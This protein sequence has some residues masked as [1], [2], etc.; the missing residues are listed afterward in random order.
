MTEQQQNAEDKLA[1]LLVQW[2][3]AWDLN[4]DIP[5][6]DLCADCPEL[7][8]PLERQIAMLK[9]MAWMKQD[10]AGEVPRS[11]AEETDPLL[12]KTLAG[13]YRIDRLI[14]EGGFGRV[15]RGF[16][17]ELQRQVAIKVARP[18]RV[19]SAEQADDLLE[20]ARRA[21]R[22]RHPGIVSV[23]DAGRDNGQVFIVSDLIEGESLADLI[24]TSR[25]GPAEAARLLA[26]IADALQFA[27]DQGF[28]H[29]DIKPSNILI[30]RQGRPLLTDFGIAA[31]A[32]Q[33]LRGE[34]VN[35][36]TLP[37]M[38]PEQVSGEVHLIDARTDV[39]ALGVVFYEL[40]TGRLPHQGRTP[41]ALR[42][43]IL[44]RQPAPP[45]SINPAASKQIEQVCLRALAKHPAD[46]FATADELATSLRKCLT[47]KSQAGDRGWLIAVGSI[48]AAVA[49]LMA[50]QPSWLG[51]SGSSDNSG[52]MSS[53]ADG[54]L[55]FDGFS[56]IVT[57]VVRF[58]PVTLEAWVRPSKY[59]NRSHY[60]I[61]SDIP[62]KW[63]I[64][65]GILGVK[66][67]GERIEGA[68][69]SEQVVP[70]A[71]WSHI[72]TVFAKAETRFYFNGRLILAGPPTAI[73]GGT[74]FVV[75]NVGENNPL[76]FF[77]GQ[78]R[79]VRISAGERYADDFQPEEQFT[80][81]ADAAPAKAVLIYD[82]SS[83][84]GE[85]VIDLS[86][87]GNH[88]R[89]ERFGL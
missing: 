31:S 72:A 7:V 88:G 3:E 56:R 66:L 1:S 57:P 73:S 59:E 50:F 15:Y 69:K 14:D 32:E 20:E 81:D 71:Q 26:E 86:G 23:H 79:S 39:H 28:V 55:A 75:G 38:A 64:G 8:E 11:A 44:L 40:L 34:A 82:G 5:A 2:E 68:M 54:V 21:A 29:F 19:R 61:G 87:A 51:H 53:G 9:K 58:A 4:E 45:R 67:G 10:A 89:W 52:R 27:H 46:R 6:S 83:V 12:G 76:E 18:E 78:I 13:R 33:L 65:L 63:R 24:A 70:L 47:V 85:R 17:S 60:V 62:S 84:E 42:E 22:L 30:D 74:H 25:P 80:K 36:G 49:L 43:Q 48:L 35:S 77:L 16:D 41:T 37:Y